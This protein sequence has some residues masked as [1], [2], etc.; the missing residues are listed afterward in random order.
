MS[1]SYK[2]GLYVPLEI[3]LE[4]KIS[5]KSRLVYYP[6]VPI[7]STRLTRMIAWFIIVD[8][9]RTGVFSIQH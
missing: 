9:M 1:L 4:L 6:I 5:S 2:S 3:V 8:I 7:R